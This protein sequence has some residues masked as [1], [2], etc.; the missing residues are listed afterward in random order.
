MALN[1]G[2]S[3]NDKSIKWNDNVFRMIGLDATGIQIRE[4]PKTNF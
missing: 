1:V 4:R 2:S 3:R